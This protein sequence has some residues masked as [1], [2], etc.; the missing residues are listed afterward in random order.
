M[1]RRKNRLDR[2]PI[3]YCTEYRTDIVQSL[4]YEYGYSVSYVGMKYIAL[5]F[6]LFPPPFSKLD[7]IQ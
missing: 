6:S 7:A 4:L 1:H 3:T 5:S 2:I